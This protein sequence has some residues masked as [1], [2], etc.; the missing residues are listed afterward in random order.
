MTKYFFKTATVAQELGSL[1]FLSLMT[2][3]LPL[4]YC[5]IAVTSTMSCLKM[6]ITCHDQ[7][8]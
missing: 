6:V 7:F 4:H 8:T 5:S 3:S 1:P 2:K